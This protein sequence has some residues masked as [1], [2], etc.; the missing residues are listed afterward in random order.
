MKKVTEEKVAT[1]K[2]KRTYSAE[3]GGPIY[4]GKVFAVPPEM[5][6]D[7]R[8]A[9]FAT[10]KK[11]REHIASFTEFPDDVLERASKP[12]SG[13][14][15]TVEKRTALRYHA[16]AVARHEKHLAALEAELAGV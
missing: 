9:G 8:S 6:Q 14:A 5:A 4:V 13:L 15:K 2:K 3:E 1:E 12:L 16:A 10:P 7:L 11:V